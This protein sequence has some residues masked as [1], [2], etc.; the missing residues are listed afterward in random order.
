MFVIIAWNKRKQSRGCLATNVKIWV[1]SLNRS[2]R[3]LNRDV[4]MR[5]VQ[6]L[7]DG[8]QL[9]RNGDRPVVRF[10]GFWGS[11]KYIFRKETF[12]FLLYVWNKFFWGQNFGVTKNWR[13]TLPEWPPWLRS[14]MEDA[15]V[16]LHSGVLKIHTLCTPVS[17]RGVI[18]E[19]DTVVVCLRLHPYIRG[20]AC[21]LCSLRGLGQ[22][23]RAGRKLWYIPFCKLNACGFVGRFGVHSVQRCLLWVRMQHGPVQ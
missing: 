8:V 13:G 10:Y 2:K 11:A 12:L 16:G 14:W 18:E 4:G 20:V 7:K 23:H 21:M 3:C 9:V 5:D 22:D 19:P 17:F 6:F 15:V 1:K